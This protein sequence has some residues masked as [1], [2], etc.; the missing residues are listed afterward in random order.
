MKIRIVFEY[1][2][3]HRTATVSSLIPAPPFGL[4]DTVS[5]LHDSHFPDNAMKEM[6]RACKAAV[7]QKLDQIT[8]VRSSVQ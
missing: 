2:T 4:R 1:D 3:E 6:R 8:A 7:E 5:V